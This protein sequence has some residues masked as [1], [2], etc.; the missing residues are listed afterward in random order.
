MQMAQGAELR[1]RTASECACVA[2]SPLISRTRKIALSAIQRINLPVSSW[3]LR[4]KVH[5]LFAVPNLLAGHAGTNLNSIRLAA[6][7]KA[8]PKWRVREIARPE[9]LC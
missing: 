8:R 6:S 2:S 3:P 4:T 7:T 9:L 5:D 1:E